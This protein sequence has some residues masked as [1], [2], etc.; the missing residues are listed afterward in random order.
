MKGPRS[1]HRFNVLRIWECPHCQK[2]AF[3][4]ARVAHRACVC[5]GKDRPTWMRLIE[6]SPPYRRKKEE[7]AP[8]S[9]TAEPAALPSS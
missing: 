3:E 5:L 1:R 7:P 2:R 6:L 4:P 8:E 9:P